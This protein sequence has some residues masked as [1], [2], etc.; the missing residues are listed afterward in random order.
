MLSEEVESLTINELWDAKHFFACTFFLIGKLLVHPRKLRCDQL[1]R[2]I[3]HYIFGQMSD[4]RSVSIDRNT[5]R[6]ASRASL[7]RKDEFANMDRFAHDVNAAR[8][9]LATPMH[10][11]DIA[12]KSPK[13]KMLLLSR[14]WKIQRRASSWLTALSQNPDTPFS[15]RKC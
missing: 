14:C 3:Q 2:I 7:H 8:F 5:D 15:S 4:E 13:S 9:A 12:S 6:F 1:R 11:E 10:S